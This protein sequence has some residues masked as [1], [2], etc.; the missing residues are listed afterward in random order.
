MAGESIDLAVRSLKGLNQRG[1]W[2]GPGCGI[3]L[4]HRV[5]GHVAGHLSAFVAADASGHNRQQAFA[6]QLVRILWPY[7][8]AA[9]FI[10]IAARTLVGQNAGHD[11]SVKDPPGQAER[12]RL[13]SVSLGR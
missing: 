13:A 8:L 4:A 2:I 6:R 11:P 12:H 3:G 9:V 5:Y 10:R 7:H 1:L